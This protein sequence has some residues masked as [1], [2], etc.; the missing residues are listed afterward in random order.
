MKKLTCVVMVIGIVFLCGI[1]TVLAGEWPVLLCYDDEALIFFGEV[2]AYGSKNENGFDNITVL[3][4]QKI[5]GDMEIGIGITYKNINYP[6]FI[7]VRGET[8]LFTYYR[9][10][11]DICRVTSTD[12]RTLEVIEGTMSFQ[13]T[14]QE[15]LNDGLYEQAESERLERKQAQKQ[16]VV[17]ILFGLIGCVVGT[18][19]TAG[20]AMYLR[21][22]K[23]RKLSK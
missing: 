23:E 4:T 15:Y 6:G 19:I 12:T 8:Y 21:K 3:P 1:I 20:T 9:K 17:N 13:D 14:L 16:L 2:L 22:R 7:L 5:K 10:C 18:V 11:L